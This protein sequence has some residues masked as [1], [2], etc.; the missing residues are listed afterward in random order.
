MTSINE[1]PVFAAGIKKKEM[2]KKNN[3][4]DC[5]RVKACN[6]FTIGCKINTNI[7]QYS[8]TLQNIQ[9]VCI[10][11]VGYSPLLFDLFYLFPAAQQQMQPPVEA[12][13]QTRCPGQHEMSWNP[14]TT[15]RPEHGS[16][17]NLS[18][19]ASESWQQSQ[20]CT[21]LLTHDCPRSG[22]QRFRDTVKL[23][24]STKQNPV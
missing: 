20:Y 18:C 11:V 17:M 24:T 14:L 5:V 2:N 8:Q 4:Y 13:W 19:P 23:S 3:S 21:S 9:Q 6:L 1:C 15:F 22:G 7:W 10:R 12:V 16:F